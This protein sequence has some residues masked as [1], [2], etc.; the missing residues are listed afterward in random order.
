MASRHKIDVFGRREAMFKSQLQKYLTKYIIRLP[1]L[2]IRSF[3]VTCISRQEVKLEAWG[4]KGVV[5]H[6]Q[7]KYHCKR[8]NAFKCLKSIGDISEMQVV[9]NGNISFLIIS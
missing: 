4:D 3:V 5:H 9:F 6:R 8:Y 1:E 7:V 2:G